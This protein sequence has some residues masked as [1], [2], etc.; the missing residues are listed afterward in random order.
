MFK[1]LLG[2]VAQGK[3]LTREEAREAMRLI[4]DGEAHPTQIAS[5]LTALRMK[6]ETVDEIIGF[7]ETMRKK[8]VSL[9]TKGEE[10]LDTCGTGGDGGISFNISTAAAIVAAAGGARV[11]KHGNRAV[12]SKSGSA[13]VLE[14]LGV[15]I[16]SS[17]KEAI[18]CLEE[19]NLCFLFAPQY[20]QAMKHAVE[21][22]RQL[23]F[24]TVF[25]LLGPLTNPACAERQLLGIYDRNL[26]VKVA[27]VLVELGVKRALVV[28][29]ADGLDE[30]S[31]SG[32]TYVVEVD[33][34]MISPYTIHPEM[35]GL[36]VHPLE[37]VAG[38]D[39]VENARIIRRVFDGEKGAYRD[40][41]VLNTAAAFYVG[42]QV[43]SIGEGVRLAQEMIDIGEAKRKLEQLVEVTG[44]VSHAS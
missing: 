9:E 33:C 31:I 43:A 38:G 39:A 2:Q 22:R 29:G 17:S 8:A 10:L 41:V 34:G 12:S 30:I 24:R 27:E 7:V 14:A 37:N 5:F 23:G 26:G 32:F 44:G 19:T 4:M 3:S 16:T 20:H 1:Q 18:R 6:G 40:I 36:S 28:A 21:P 15:T 25:N 42:G 13:D 11:A 35:F